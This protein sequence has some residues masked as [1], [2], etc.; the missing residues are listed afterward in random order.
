V[1]FNINDALRAV[2]IHDIA[3]PSAALC[4]RE[5]V[6]SIGGWMNSQQFEDT[7]LFAKLAAKFPFEFLDESLTLYRRHEGNRSK[8]HTSGRFEAYMEVLD[9]VKGL[10]INLNKKLIKDFK[11]HAYYLVSH[12]HRNAGRRAACIQAAYHAVILAP[13]AALHWVTLLRALLPARLDEAL[14]TMQNSIVNKYIPLEIRKMDI[15]K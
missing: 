7:K 4:S 6:E 11:A 12:W 3:I 15:F 8:A 13:H 5:A 10:G 9:V 14:Y 2:L 1:K